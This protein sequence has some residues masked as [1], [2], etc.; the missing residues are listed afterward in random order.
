[1]RP[2]SREKQVGVKGVAIATH[3]EVGLGGEDSEQVQIQNPTE[4]QVWE[5]KQ[6]EIEVEKKAE[7]I[8]WGQRGTSRQRPMTTAQGGRPG[9]SPT[10]QNQEVFALFVTIGS[11]V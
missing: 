8:T 4:V 6:K 5:G 1:M 10:G 9:K 11:T 3:P 7:A 2:E